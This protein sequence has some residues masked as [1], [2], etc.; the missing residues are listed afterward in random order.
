MDKN[1]REKEYDDIIVGAGSTG[2]VIAA[3]LSEDPDR[4]VLLVEAGP[5]FGGHDFIPPELLNPYYPIVKGYN[6]DIRAYM[7]EQDLLADLQGV[8]TVTENT[9][10]ENEQYATIT[11]TS[12]KTTHQ[13][14]SAIPRFTYPVGKVVGGSSAIN[15][16]MALRGTIEDYAQWQALGL[17]LW[18]WE[19]ILS[20]FKRVENDQNK[21][22]DIYSQQGSIPIDRIQKESLCPLQ[23]DFVNICKSMGYSYTDA[24][25]SCATGLSLMARN[26][27]NGQRISTATGYLDVARD[28]KNL[29]IMANT[30]VDKVVIK[31]GK[32]TGI[33]VSGTVVSGTVVSQKR[34]MQ[35]ISARRVIISAGAIH[36]PTILMR[37]GIGEEQQLSAHGIVSLVDLPGVGQN[38]I[39]HAAVG[40]WAIP[41]SDVNPLDK[42]VHQAMLRYSSAVS[43]PFDRNDMSLYMLSSVDTEQYPALKVV[44]NSLSALA[45]SSVLGKPQSRGNVTLAS[46]NCR[47]CPNVVLNCA[48]ESSDKQKIM[49]GVRLAWDILQQAPLRSKYKKIFAWNQRIIDSDKLLSNTIATFVR[50]SWHAVGTAQMGQDHDNMAV[51][52]QYG[53]VFGIDRLVVADASIMPTIPS[54]P[55]NLTCMMIGEVLADTLRK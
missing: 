21:I 48:K 38:L 49:E 17:P 41:E 55:T 10:A 24:N 4:R 6:W 20:G 43:P 27:M 37:S 16:A 54:V 33:V 30:L 52:D 35:T 3:R 36:S 51:V 14:S 28:R 29:T 25:D 34:R 50:G 47:D 26:I 45:I 39:D 2:A 53:H 40:I 1:N 42:E 15:G 13:K 11:H 8:N 18:S 9:G 46:A 31:D 44:L 22:G 12:I 5:D 32:A 23:R 7:Q 19:N